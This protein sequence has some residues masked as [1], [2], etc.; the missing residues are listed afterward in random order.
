MLFERLSEDEKDIIE[1]MRHNYTDADSTD[2]FEGSFVDTKTFLRFWEMEKS[3]MA[4]AFN[5]GLIV[6]KPINITLEDDEL[7][8][9]MSRVL[10]QNDSIVLKDNIIDAFKDNNSD[11]WLDYV[12]PING[13]TYNLNEIFK[14][15]LFDTDTWINNVY[16]GP[17]CEIKAT[18]GD[19]FKLV[20]GCKLM[21]LIGRMVKFCSP[22]TAELFEKLRL[23]QSQVMNEA[24]ITANLCISIHPLD[25]LTASLNDNDWRSCMC[26]DDGEY[27]RGVVEMMNSPM[28]VVAYVEAKSQHL[29]WFHG[30]DNPRLTWNSKRWREFFIVRP[31]IISG[32]KGYPYWNRKLEDAALHMLHDMFAPIFG[33]KYS[34]KIY[35]WMCGNS[36]QDEQYGIDYAPNMSCG[37][38]MYNDF[39]TDNEYH[40][41]LA[42]DAVGEIDKSLCYRGP[43]CHVTDIFYSGISECVCCGEENNF[44]GESEIV[45]TECCT[46]YYCSHCGEPISNSQDLYELNG[47]YYCSYCYNELEHCDCCD[48]PID[49][50]NDE[51]TMR[52]VVGWDE[53]DL[54]DT[55]W[56]FAST[57]DDVMCKHWDEKYGG[58]HVIIRNICSHCARSV[59]ISGINEL[60]QEHSVYRGNKSI[61]AE[62]YI[63][64]PLSHFTPEGLK[65]LYD[66][67]DIEYFKAQHKDTETISA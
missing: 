41:M 22:R 17:S 19:T 5:G 15:T 65:M 37:P 6:K 23:Q 2:F 56:G 24:K 7:H 3:H 54:K 63:V 62:S 16:N 33:V 53:I 21:K 40:S 60:Y 13:C 42:V 34:P 35:T 29:D 28:V 38:A 18:N 39:Y 47:N 58:P 26:W 4:D 1:I 30:I 31:D 12:T 49:L 36:I 52:F 64:I 14:Y 57:T 51:S 46:H 67:R 11:K 27:R 10:W 50:D 61:F 20:H 32:I 43:I 8:D 45:C 44:D 55:N 9:K 25:Y 59:F 66:E 48:T